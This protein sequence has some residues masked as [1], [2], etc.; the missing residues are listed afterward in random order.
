M[1]PDGYLPT[2]AARGNPAT[3]PPMDADGRLAAA[4]AATPSWPATRGPTRTSRLTATQTAVR[5]RAQPDRRPLPSSLSQEDKFQIARRV[6]IAEQQYITYQE[7]LP[8]MGVALPA[9]HGYDP[10]ST[11]P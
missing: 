8:A 3:A 2:R 11:R 7:F 6:V 9:Y 1:L 4:P 10:A 5:P